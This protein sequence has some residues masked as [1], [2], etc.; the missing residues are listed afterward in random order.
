MINKT[1]IARNKKARFNYEIL[2]VYEAGV[3]LLGSEVKSLR[4]GNASLPESYIRIDNNE[5]FLVGCYIAEFKQ[6]SCFNHDPIRNRTLLLR[7]KEIRRISQVLDQKGLAFIPLKL[8]FNEKGLVKVTVA[9]AKGKKNYD[10]RKKL[11]KDFD[12]KQMEY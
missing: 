6:A 2:E 11:N 5:A 7:K 3:S 4:L 8:Y 12:K 1:I 9:I 10:K